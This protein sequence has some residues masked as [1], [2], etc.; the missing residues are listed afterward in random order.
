M[1]PEL[2]CRHLAYN[3]WATNRV[4]RAC[5]ALTAEQRRHDFRTADKSVEGTLLHLFR[6]ER[7]WLQRL[8]GEQADYAE[9]DDRWDDLHERWA[10][11]QQNWTEWIANLSSD[12]LDAVFEYRDLKGHARANARWESILHVVNHSTHHRGQVS[13]FLRALGFVP[14]PLDYI[15]YVREN[16]RP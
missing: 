1:N 16:S 4:L 3:A 13:G 9:P 14:P 15:A 6:S 7:L 10:S 5:E 2:F 8:K 11:V 12:D